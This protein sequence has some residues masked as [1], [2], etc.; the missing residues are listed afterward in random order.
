VQ[1]AY[2]E[3][4]LAKRKIW[5]WKLITQLWLI[6]G[7]AAAL[8][9]T[10]QVLTSGRRNRAARLPIGAFVQVAALGRQAER[11]VGQAADGVR[12]ERLET[13]PTNHLGGVL[14]KVLLVR[15]DHYAVADHGHIVTAQFWINI[16]DL[17]RNK[18][19]NWI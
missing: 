7:Q 18:V 17:F 1:Q 15:V 16:R 3:E 4:K 2:L 11:L 5:I 14:E 13:R 8:E 9:A 12:A 10:G 6:S 19:I